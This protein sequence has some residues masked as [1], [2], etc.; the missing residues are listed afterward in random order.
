V[1][2]S[3]PAADAD[4]D[5]VMSSRVRLARNVAGFP[6]VGRAT[7]PQRRE[8]LDAVRAAVGTDERT[9][10]LAGGRVGADS[11]E[12]VGWIDLATLPRRDRQLL[13][14]RHLISRQFAEGD[15]PRALA[16]TT[17]GRFAMMVNEEDHLRLQVM[18]GGNRL[19][20]AFD[21]AMRAESAL[22]SRLDFAFHRRWGY[23]TACPT[24]VGCGI[25]IGVMVHLRALRVT[26]DIEK[27]KRAAKELHLAVRGFHGEGTDAS[28]DWYQVSNQRTLGIGEEALL[29]QFA[30]SVVPAIVAHEREARAVLLDRPAHAPGGPGVPRA[31]NAARRPAPRAGRGDEASLQP[32]PRGVPRPGAGDRPRHGRPADDPPAVRAPARG[33]SVRGHRRRRTLGPCPHGARGVRRVALSLRPR[34]RRRVSPRRERPRR[35]GPPTGRSRS[36][37]P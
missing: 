33:R 1:T 17:D 19:R 36:P 21:D 13:W 4:R 34:R 3:T 10:G 12:A 32:A 6:F 8:V 28:G 9:L 35:S 37:C 27:V 25:R 22:G 18:R 29:R 23:L 24:N 11:A 16:V 5:V 2:A 30:D 7:H 15:S 20:E 14:E 26:N 31:R